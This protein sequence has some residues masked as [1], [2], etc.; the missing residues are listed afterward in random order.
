MSRSV[1]SPEH[2]VLSH[3]FA[4]HLLLRHQ[5]HVPQPGMERFADGIAIQ[6]ATGKEFALPP[7]AFDKA[8]N[9]LL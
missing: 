8:T 9:P 4:D 7:H 3:Q 2:A 1:Q 6:P 5:I